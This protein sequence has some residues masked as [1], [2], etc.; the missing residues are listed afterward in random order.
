MHS[1]FRLIGSV[2]ILALFASCGDDSSTSPES[3]SSAIGRRGVTITA[4]NGGETFK[5]GDSLTVKWSVTN[6]SLTMAAVVMLCGDNSTEIPLYPNG[7]T[8]DMA[9]WQNVR[10]KMPAPPVPSCRI[11][12]RD[13]TMLGIYDTTD[14][15]FTVN[16]K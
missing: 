2:A 4:P 12:V 11:K 10:V 15:R 16:P 5:V 13:Y 6:D 7:I 1:R 8:R 3:T 14:A 9:E